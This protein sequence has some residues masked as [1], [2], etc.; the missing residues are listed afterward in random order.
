MEMLA[1]VVESR[2]KC[3]P[4]LRKMGRSRC[5]EF[6]M[7]SEIVFTFDTQD[8]KSHDDMILLETAKL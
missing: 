7:E 1:C 4:F 8:L 5:N 2:A 6:L 3:A